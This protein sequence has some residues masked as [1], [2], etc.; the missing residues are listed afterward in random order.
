MWA[1][2]CVCVCVCVCVFVQV[3]KR[4]RER[5]FELSVRYCARLKV[6]FLPNSC[7][8]FSEDSCSHQAGVFRFSIFYLRSEL[9]TC[10]IF[11]CFK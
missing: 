9:G 3:L 11:E 7:S 4:S 8:I 10:G 1:G 2:V 5:L 6:R